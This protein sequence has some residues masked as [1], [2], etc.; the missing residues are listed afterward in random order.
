ME[1]PESVQPSDGPDSV[2]A[3]HLRR[4]QRLAWGAAAVWIILTAVATPWVSNQVLTAYVANAATNAAGN[5]RAIASIVDRM[6]HELA[7]TPR[8]LAYSGELQALISRYNNLGPSW[9]EL[10]QERRRE[11]LR[12]DPDVV[13]INQRLTGVRASLN[14]DLVYVLDR[15]GIRIVTSDWD[16]P[17]TL[18]GLRFDD[19]EYFKEAMNDRG[20]HMFAVARTTRN[21]N[22]FFSAPMG[23]ENGTIGVVVV[24]QDSE[25]LGSSLAGSRDLA[26]IVD[27][28]GMIVAASRIDL[29]LSHVGALSAA[30][31]DPDTLREVYGQDALRALAVA[32]PRRS[33]HPEEW[34][35]DGKPHLVTR[36]DLTI[37]YRLLVLS[38]IDQLDVVRS[39]HYAIGGMAGIFGVLVVLLA[40]RRAESVARQRH[41][42]RLTTALNEKLIVLNKDKDRYLGIAA[43]DLRNPLSS[44]RG[45]S[46]MMLSSPLEP[47]QQKEFLTTIHRTSDE[48]L[49]LVNDL[50]DVSVIESGK[51]DLKLGDHDLNKLV[52][53]RLRHLEPQARTKNIAIQLEAPAGQRANIDAARFGQVIDNLVSNA[54]KFSPP[55][56]TVAVS[57]NS[58]PREFTLN[59]EDQG[60]GISE[61]D[62]KL[63]FRSF[64]KLSARPTGGEKST[65][66]GLAI[67]KKIIDAHG[68]RIEVERAPAGGTRFSVTMPSAGA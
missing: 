24:R 60:P 37:G 18:L 32:R 53:R 68:G 62:R 28:A 33:L 14:Y 59:V 40:R 29:A 13:R 8:V 41:H 54:I 16:R 43:H 63:L 52:S 30:T 10:A 65:G 5:A 51:L 2:L 9:A 55:G 50:L 7:A 49:G 57:L 6:F 44:M 35:L 11:V 39:L 3:D 15:N 61:D 38:P 23:D 20:G 27:R 45:L 22:L 58:T 36:T 42:D 56:T 21:P 67:V 31:P 4:I 47:E 46:E 34:L 1:A 17:V 64:Q 12:K 25:L 48:M 66:L 19:R 26:L